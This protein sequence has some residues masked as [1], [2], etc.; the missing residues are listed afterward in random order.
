MTTQAHCSITATNVSPSVGGTITVTA[1]ATTSSPPVPLPNRQIA[2]YHDFNGVKY[3]DGSGKTNAQGQFALKLTFSTAG[4]R[5]Y[6]AA[7][8]GDAASTS[9]ALVV[10]VTTTQPPKPPVPQLKCLITATNKSPP[11]GGSSIITATAIDPLLSIVEVN[12]PPITNK[13]I[14]IYHHL[15][16]K[17]YTDKEGKTD[18]HG[19]FSVKQT[20][21]S[22]GER[23]YHA[24]LIGD[25]ASTSDALVITAGATQTTLSANYTTPGLNQKIT[26]VATLKAGSE[27]LHSKSLT[28]YHTIEGVRYD[29]QTAKVDSSGQVKFVM[30]WA[31]TGDRTFYAIFK[32]D[33]Q[34]SASTSAALI[35][36]VYTVAPSDVPFY[37]SQ[38]TIAGPKSAEVGK[39]YNITGQASTVPVS[40]IPSQPISTTIELWSST[41]L[42]K[43]FVKIGSTKTDAKGKW[44]VGR[45]DSKI[46]SRYIYAKVIKTFIS[47]KDLEN[48]KIVLKSVSVKASTSAT[49]TVS[50]VV[51]PDTPVP[52]DLPDMTGE[53][54]YMLPVTISGATWKAQAIKKNW[55]NV[56]FIDSN[57]IEWGGSIYW[58]DH[59]VLGRIG[60]AQD[61][62]GYGGDEI[63]FSAAMK[64]ND[65]KKNK[66]LFDQWKRNGTVLQFASTYHSYLMPV[67]IKE[68]TL[69]SLKDF[70][71]SDYYEY[72]F[73]L[74]E[75][76]PVY[77]EW[78]NLLQDQSIVSSACGKRKDTLSAKNGVKTK[79]VKNAYGQCIASTANLYSVFG[80]IARWLG[81]P[82]NDYMMFVSGKSPTILNKVM[83][84]TK[85]TKV[86]VQRVHTTTNAAA[87]AWWSD[88]K[89]PANKV[90][91]YGAKPY[92]LRI[93]VDPKNS[94]NKS[95]YKAGWFGAATAI[96][97]DPTFPKQN[98]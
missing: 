24:A 70:P 88:Q 59:Q 39:T 8:I 91:K 11:I 64:G 75:F 62:H 27:S 26:F 78:E 3:T 6:H 96:P 33:K 2:I 44:A 76:K 5:T 22:A 23:T 63:S 77:I 21:K 94:K 10:T 1:T 82:T 14:A 30:S 13:P 74:K 37:N 46:G 67:V 71:A 86:F 93:Y 40:Q 79:W 72:T 47:E 89:F 87:Y 84:D 48:G 54:I 42:T 45:K 41:L 60:D 73:K 49:I 50:V 56:A 19:R 52:V 38:S 81:R 61:F 66:K 92:V 90:S 20:F 36:H 28:L 68:F 31:T 58:E 43:N 32:G 9:P 97:K 95:N 65:A 69:N 98:Q 29:D 55:S 80:V 17:K 83:K 57:D 34:Y 7:L 53:L 16:G 15:K 35:I 51:G 18:A 12:P 25:A 85:I 4:K